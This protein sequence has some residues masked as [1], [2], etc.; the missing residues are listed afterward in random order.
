[1]TTLADQLTPYWNAGGDQKPTGEGR[2]ADFEKGVI[3]KGPWE[4][5]A[6]GF[7]E[8]TRRNARAMAMGGV[9]VALRSIS[10]RIRIAS[11]E[12]LQIDE[13]YGDLLNRTIALTTAQVIQLVPHDGSLQ[14][15]T[16]HRFYTV[17][18]QAYLN[19]RKVFYAV[20]E[21]FSGLQ[22]D[23]REAL[24][25]VGQVWVPCEANRAFLIS[26]GVPE[27]KVRVMPCPFLPNDT[28]LAQA[29]TM[30]RKRNEK[31][32]FYHIGKWEPR[33]EQRNIL[34]AFLAAFRPGECSLLVKTSDKSPFFDG[35][36]PSVAV[37]VSDW[38]ADP[39]VQKNGWTKE[40]VGQDV[41]VVQK[42]LSQNTLN[43]LHLTSDCYVTLARGEGFDMPAFDAKLVGNLMLYVPSGGPQDFAH[44]E[45]VRVEPSGFVPAHPFYRWH[46]GSTYLDYPFE[47]AV[48][49]FRAAAKKIRNGVT[50]KRDLSSF[51]GAEVGKRMAASLRELG[52]IGF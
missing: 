51:S 43:L 18:Q 52:D 7:S 29:A 21:R 49:G 24:K 41:R 16:T 38:L 39:A 25:R 32:T 13:Q 1:M 26:E 12:E 19:A 14:S 28:L 48:E 17:E 22:E 15:F 30:Q 42:R 5:F 6:D 23:D 9:P 10:P 36:P 47:A 34:G 8:H 33:K 35:Y 3:L 27:E 50:A 2:A 4:T 46:K 31:P 20:W 40:N 11:G 44:P 37:A 45:D